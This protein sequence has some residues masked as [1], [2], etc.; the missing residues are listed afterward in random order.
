MGEGLELPLTGL[1]PLRGPDAWVEGLAKPLLPLRVLNAIP[2]V[3]I[4]EV[5]PEEVR[6]LEHLTSGERWLACRTSSGVLTWWGSGLD[7]A[8]S[9]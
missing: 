2:K 3:Q 5:V 7:Y 9:G 4:W 6:R 8:G 1:A